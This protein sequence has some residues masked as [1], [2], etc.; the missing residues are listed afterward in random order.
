M[1]RTILF[2]SHDRGGAGGDKQN[3][4]AQTGGSGRII[5][6]CPSASNISVS[7]GTNSVATDS[8]TGDKIATFN[9]T[10]TIDF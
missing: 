6:R 2:P 3:G 7:P 9:V 4:S 8:P 1:C 10:G 5:L